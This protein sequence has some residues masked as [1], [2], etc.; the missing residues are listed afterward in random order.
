MLA[1]AAAVGGEAMPAVKATQQ[2]GTP[3]GKAKL[4]RGSFTL[5][6]AEYAVLAEL[7]GAC[8]KNGL[9]VKKNQLLRVGIALLREC[10]SARLGDMVAALPSV[11]PKPA[12]KNK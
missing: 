7:K 6:K 1:N 11:T 9:A 12:K 10:D 4:I 8:L 3:S 5:P 2:P